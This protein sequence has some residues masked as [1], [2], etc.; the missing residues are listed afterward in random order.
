MGGRPISHHAVMATT[1]AEVAGGGAALLLFAGLGLVYVRTCCRG[2]T[3]SR[4]HALARG[5]MGR[6]VELRRSSSAR[7]IGLVVIIVG[8]F[9]WAAGRTFD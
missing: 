4:I 8:A 9:A 6:E 2:S 7:G 1:G 5:A 3:V